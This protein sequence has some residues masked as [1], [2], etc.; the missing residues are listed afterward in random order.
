[1]GC[2]CKM[3][4][5]EPGRSSERGSVLTGSKGLLAM[6]GAV[7]SKPRCGCSLGCYTERLIFASGSETEE[8]KSPGLKPDHSPAAYAG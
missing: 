1:M 7:K 6:T 4:G 2:G 5:L 3:L 8:E